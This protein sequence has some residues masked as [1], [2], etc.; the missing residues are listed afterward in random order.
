MLSIDTI[1][2]FY[3]Q[4][5]GGGHR[6]GLVAVYNLGYATGRSQTRRELGLEDLPGDSN[7]AGVPFGVQ[8]GEGK[9]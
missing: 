3:D 6:I 2:Q 4:N 5:I 1:H 9:E 8:P 7:P